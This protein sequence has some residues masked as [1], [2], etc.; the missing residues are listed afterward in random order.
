MPRDVSGKQTEIA[1]AVKSSSSVLGWGLFIT[2]TLSPAFMILG[3]IVDSLLWYVPVFLTFGLVAVYLL[4]RRRV[5]KL[6]Y[7]LWIDAEVYNPDLDTMYLVVSAGIFGFILLWLSIILILGSA[8]AEY[9]WP[10]TVIGTTAVPCVVLI[11]YHIAA[12]RRKEKLKGMRIRYVRVNEKDAVNIIEKALNDLGLDY[13]KA[14]EGSKSTKLIPTLRIQEARL[15]IRIVQSGIN[16]SLIELKE[17]VGVEVPKMR[18]V[19]KSID[20]SLEMKG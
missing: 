2:I 9:Y 16:T 3:L 8:A 18:S 17:E 1:L 14:T 11:V 5:F 6:K 10:N 12:K 20:I 4:M 7:Q 15:D 13:Q 19:E